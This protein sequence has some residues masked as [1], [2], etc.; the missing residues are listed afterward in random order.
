MS[1][2]L[3]L[4]DIFAYLVPGVLFLY[5]LNEFLALLHL[6]TID[7]NKLANPIYAILM[8]IVA[9]FTGSMLYILF[10]RL[11]YDRMYRKIRQTALDDVKQ[12][13]PEIMI[14]YSVDSA[15]TLAEI[16]RIRNYQALHDAE[17]H[18]VNSIMMRNLSLCL[19]FYVL[20][21]AISAVVYQAWI[22][23]LPFGVVAI[24]F[25]PLTY[26]LAKWYDRWHYR[27]IFSEA[28]SYGPDLKSFLA[29]DKP[30]WKEKPIEQVIENDP[31]NQ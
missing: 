15:G 7:V 19:S 25:I 2:T 4:Y 23:F 18:K 11:W 13:C 10:D 31:E 5:I 1:I 20:L 24:I 21:Q 6:A 22:P 29:N 12:R 9:Y 30:C 27:A 17:R 16:L 14:Q 8:L 26:R 28:L 3:G